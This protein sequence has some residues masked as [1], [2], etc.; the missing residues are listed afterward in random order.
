MAGTT[1]R[2]GFTGGIPAAEPA[3]R[4][5][6]EGTAESR[7]ARTLYGRDI[8]LRRSE[9]DFKSGQDTPPPAPATVPGSAPAL[10]ERVGA[11]TPRGRAATPYPHPPSHTGKS[12][13]PT[14]ARLL[15]RWGT[16]GG[17]LRED[18][19]WEPDGETMLVPRESSVWRSVAIVLGTAFVSFTLVMLIVRPG[20]RPAAPKTAT[21][22]P[23]VI[24]PAAAPAPIPEAAMP[25]VQPAAA[26]TSGTL[27]PTQQEATATDEPPAAR[28][29]R[30]PAR[31]AAPSPR[32]VSR[33]R[34]RPEDPDSLMPLTF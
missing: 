6:P 14:I 3:E 32:S 4:N 17:F 1:T 24:M 34:S 27:N 30:P 13:Y 5:G 21:P 10:S 16:A 7:P 2:Y 20:S 8:H 15:G 33:P 22:E 29:I 19:G 11:A 9:L 18:G 23:A 25:V 31:K 26:S 28:P 12:G